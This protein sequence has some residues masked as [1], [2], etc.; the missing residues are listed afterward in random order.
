MCSSNRETP[1]GLPTLWGS[2]DDLAR[3]GEMTRRSGCMDA[4]I[5]QSQQNPHPLGW[6]WMQKED[7]TKA[8]P[9]CLHDQSGTAVR[10]A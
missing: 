3:W 1:P 4:P 2:V 5:W 6:T 7:G 8:S 9:I 10:P